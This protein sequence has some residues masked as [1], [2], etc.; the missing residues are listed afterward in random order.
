MAGKTEKQLPSYYMFPRFLQHV[1]ENMINENILNEVKL[2]T[3]V[4][5]ICLSQTFNHFFPEERIE[6]LRENSWVKDP[7]TFQ[8]L[9]SIIELNLV[10][11]EKN[12]LLQLSSSYAL[13]T[14]YET[15]SLSTF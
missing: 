7:L 4:Y 9:E 5:L 3:L 1:E 15:L 2:E 6:T 11:E 10:P 12:E 8:N 13:K 14:D